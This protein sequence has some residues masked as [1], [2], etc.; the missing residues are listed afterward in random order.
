MIKRFKLLKDENRVIFKLSLIASLTICILFFMF[1]P[2]ISPPEQP[3]REY[4][5]LLFTINDLAPSTSQQNI[6]SPKP[7]VPKIIVPDAVEEPEILPDQDIVSS[8]ESGESGNEKGSSNIS[9]EGSILDMPQLP[10]VPR[11]IL[12]VL[13]KNVEKSTKGYIELSLKIGTDGHVIGYKI[14][15]NTTGSDQALQSVI[16]AAYKSKWEPVKIKDNKVI[17]WVEKTYS[18]N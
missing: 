5:S 17:Y 3:P 10:F 9:G 8:T 4:Q 11:Q 2:H 15:G 18:F 13:P 14:I 6:K 12:E 1:F 7:P 16:M